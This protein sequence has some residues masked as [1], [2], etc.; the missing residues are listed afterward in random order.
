MA[1]HSLFFLADEDVPFSKSKKRRLRKKRKL[2]E[3]K[4]KKL[5]KL[6]KRAALELIAE[7]ANKAAKT[8]EIDVSVTDKKQKTDATVEEEENKVGNVKEN[9][10]HAV[11][12]RME[13]GNKI[14]LEKTAEEDIVEEKEMP[15][16][17][18]S[19]IL[20]DN[21]YDL[22]VEKDAVGRSVVGKEAENGPFSEKTERHVT[23]DEIENQLNFLREAIEEMVNAE[24]KNKHEISPE[25]MVATAVFNYMMK[26]VGEKFKTP[27][28]ERVQ[29]IIFLLEYFNM[30]M[31]ILLYLILFY[32]VIFSIF[33]AC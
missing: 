33:C 26:K 24:K 11:V 10:E 32:K 2:Q 18:G 21:R 16:T 13:S 31:M 15:E 8:K 6:A 27:E 28:M 3:I 19:A 25:V 23:K 9:S 20:K 29:D 14:C 7:D 4:V 12:V 17:E 22:I 30:Y 5:E 1:F